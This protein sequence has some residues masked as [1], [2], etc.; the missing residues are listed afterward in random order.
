MRGNNRI[1]PPEQYYF[2]LVVISCRPDRVFHFV[3][4]LSP[5]SCSHAF[6]AKKGRKTNACRLCQTRIPV[7]KENAK[8]AHHQDKTE[9]D[10]SSCPFPAHDLQFSCSNNIGNVSG[11]EH[12]SGNNQSHNRSFYLPDRKGGPDLSG[13]NCGVVRHSRD[14]IYPVKPPCREFVPHNRGRTV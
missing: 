4:D 1:L 14:H 2:L 6:P 13:G 12:P 11:D 8:E 5:P 10:S 9:R 3:P 7:N